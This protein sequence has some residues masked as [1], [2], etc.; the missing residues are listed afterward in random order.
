M[1]IGAFLLPIGL[2]W[3]AWTSNSHISWVP[4]VIAGIPIG[5][6]ILMIF[7]QYV[8]AP[9]A[10]NLSIH[11]PVSTNTQTNNR[12]LSYIIDVYLMYANSAI[13][14][15]TF[16]RSLAGAGFPMFA[17]AMYHT[18]GVAWATSL[19]GFLNVAF[20]PVP[21]LFFKFGAKIRKMSKYSP[22]A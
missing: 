10:S 5:A 14:G 16:I 20:L 19:L 7:L 22:T 4:E 12:G 2:F 6:G 18:L 17:T 1:I 8:T 11:R 15:N 9:Y 21:I 13:A 3:F